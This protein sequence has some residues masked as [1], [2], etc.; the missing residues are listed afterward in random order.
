MSVDKLEEVQSPCIGVCSMNEVT[1]YCYGCYRTVDEI[2]SWWDMGTEAQKKLLSEL[3]V[4][5]S[6]SVSFDD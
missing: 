4:R 1:G 6:E 2:K 3:E 5:Q